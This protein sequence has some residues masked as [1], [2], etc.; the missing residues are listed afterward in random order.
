MNTTN[1]CIIFEM[2][3]TLWDA[4]DN[5]A[6][7][8]NALLHEQLC[9]DGH[10]TG[11][12]LRAVAG[13]EIAEIARALFPQLSEQE[14]LALTM[15]CMSY[16]NEYL[17]RHGGV[18]YPD[19]EAV[20]AQLSAKHPLMIVTNAADGYVDAM[21]S[22]HHLGKYFVDHETHGRTGL[23]K[24]EN[25]S[26]IMSRNGIQDAWYVGDTLKDQLACE[27]AGIPFVYAAYGFG[28]AQRWQ[29]RISCFRDLLMLFD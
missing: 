22:A 23:S 7:A 13:M 21:F 16:E 26:L 1:T 24:G 5:I 3:G 20:L 9:W 6:A 15:S 29:A 4:S 12:E 11:D 17:S 19:V 27:A 14:G 25:I 2:D 28:E 18:L 8:Y 10:C